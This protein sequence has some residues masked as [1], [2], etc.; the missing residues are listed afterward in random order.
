MRTSYKVRAYPTTEQAAVLNRTFGC[1]RLV[2]NKA[3]AWRQA[4]YRTQGIAT[5]DV[6]P[7]LI[8]PTSVTVSPIAGGGGSAANWSTRR[9]GTVAVWS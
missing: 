7:V 1:A 4:R 9:P 3:L 8:E 6:D 5:S 2:W